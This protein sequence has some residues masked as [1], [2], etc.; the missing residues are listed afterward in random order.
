MT[1]KRR[2]AS[3]S[4]SCRSTGSFGELAWHQ[5]RSW[6]ERFEALIVGA[7]WCQEIYCKEVLYATGKQAMALARGLECAGR[8]KGFLRDRFTSRL[9]ARSRR[10]MGC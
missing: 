1:V 2:L 4:S 7:S 10:P 5:K 9:G 6:P 3:A 8:V